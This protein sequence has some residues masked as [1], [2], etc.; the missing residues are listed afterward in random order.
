MSETSSYQPYRLMLRAVFF[1][2]GA[3]A[4]VFETIWFR[5]A[6]LTFGN[7]AEASSVVLSAFMA[8]LALGNYLVGRFSNGIRRPLRFFAAAE[9]CVAVAG[10]L[11][12]LILP[13]FSSLI[14]P[15]LTDLVGHPFMV[16]VVRLF[17][18]FLLLLVPST[19]MGVT[20]PIL[21]RAL[22]RSEQSFGSALGGLYGW[23][24]LG[25]VAGALC[26]EIAI[27]SWGLYE[28]T[29]LAFLLDL[30]A[31][32]AVLLL[33][34]EPTDEP[35]QEGRPAKRSPVAALLV[36]AFLSGAC[37]LA[38][39]VI[40]FRFLH[41]FV[42]STSL[43]F[44]LM[45]AVVL[46]GIGM[47]GAVGGMWI[48]R[49]PNAD[50]LGSALAFLSGAACIGLYGVFGPIHDA[51]G[52]PFAVE[53]GPVLV[54]TATL[55]L[56]VAIL[57]G[58][59]FTF[60]GSQM[61][62]RLDSPI[63]ATSRMAFWNTLGAGTGA[64]VG[65][66]VLL[67]HTG[68]EGGLWLM[69]LTY[70]IIGFLLNAR[71]WRSLSTAGPPVALLAAL[72]A[73]PF[74]S[75]SERHYPVV[76]QRFGYP[77]T[78]R[79]VETRE[80]LTETILYLEN[81][82]AGVP[83]SY[84]LVTNGFSMASSSV[85]NRRY[86]KLY[87]YLPLALHGDIRSAL[88]ISY[89]VGST[90]RSLVDSD[91]IERIDIVD[92]S[93]DVLDLS[94]V[95]YSEAGRNPVDDSRVTTFV[96]DGRQFLKVTPARYDLITSEPPP[97]KHAGVVNL[98]T[99]EYFELIHDRLTEGGICS[100]WL[101]VHTLDPSQSLAI[102]RAFLDVFED[103]SMWT[104]SGTNW[105][106]IGSRG[107]IRRTSADR[108]V[109]QWRD[110]AVRQELSA[111]GLERPAQ[112]GALFMSDPAHLRT[113]TRDVAPLVDAYPGRLGAFRIDRRSQETAYSDWMDVARAEERFR[114]SDYVCSVLPPEIRGAAEGYFRLQG[115]VN[116]LLAQQASPVTRS[117]NPTEQVGG[118]HELLVRTTLT[119]LPKWHLRVWEDLLAAIRTLSSRQSLT[120]HYRTSLAAAALA[121]RNY[122]RASVLYKEAL[123]EGAPPVPV[124]HLTLYALIRAGEIDEA[125]E[126][127]GNVR[128]EAYD[129][130][131]WRWLGGLVGRQ[132]PAP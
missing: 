26:G 77:R 42:Q 1:V 52:Q 101:P 47:G 45:L 49:R 46:A 132:V 39:E 16:N 34:K 51:L 131:Y 114:Q 55:A 7:S 29:G 67:P 120:G 75:L 4:L 106:L 109:A 57:S 56:P 111:L 91:G 124:V 72:V 60:I 38:L 8:G 22:T 79:I 24:T 80:G 113:M 92:I 10:V 74:D 100:Y 40:W 84:Q 20:L 94:R 65:G 66:Y 98:Y 82:L 105:M 21:V 70:G 93:R 127:A 119:T 76:A 69:A 48:A 95:P 122:K 108:F 64:L 33:L 87:T 9:G 126:R 11:L 31:A 73:F 71:G 99:R 19:A 125:M 130:T 85:F 118:L 3:G 88:L 83:V 89:G 32:S 41:L 62:R 53:A 116:D 43:A 129:P 59:L 107:G 25:A 18:G 2:S 78:A 104:G 37:L 90:A 12:V 68:V 103:A 117:W 28:A 54:L 27:T 14:T 102:T 81:H 96:E 17:L 44:S 63:H 13:A 23:N 61:N 128:V 110:S 5:Q 58:L 15:L 6:G 86:M 50:D 115:V 121:E 123:D 36:A 112:L 30:S 35:A 97:P